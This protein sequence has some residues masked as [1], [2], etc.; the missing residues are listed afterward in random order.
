MHTGAARVAVLLAAICAIA[1]ATSTAAYA[2]SPSD[3]R[4]PVGSTAYRQL[5]ATDPQSFD[6]PPDAEFSFQDQK[7]PQPQHTG[8]QALVRSTAS[9]FKAFPMRKSTWVILGIGGAA[10]ALAHTVDDDLSEELPQHDNL[11]KFFAPGKYLGYTWVQMGAAIGTYVIGRY[12]YDPPEGKS[13]KVSHLGFDLLRANLLTQA[14]T[15][16]VKY[17]VRR[18]RPDGTCCSFPSAHASVTFASAS[19]LERHFGYRSAWPTFVIASYVAASRLTDNKHFLSDVVF[20]AALGMASGWT[21][22]GRHGKD[23]FALFPVPMHGGVGVMMTWTP[24][25]HLPSSAE[26]P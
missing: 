11:K 22:V 17:A 10:A 18:D 25:G 6:L 8:F 2:D 24:G 15:F 9:D 23:D 21:V 16:G 5:F 19:V 12:A 7:P 3:S 4:S 26:G 20:G 13:N 1:T 14:L